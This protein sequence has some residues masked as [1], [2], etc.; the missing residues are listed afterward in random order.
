MSYSQSKYFIICSASRQIRRRVPYAGHLMTPRRLWLNKIPTLCDV[1]IEFP[2]KKTIFRPFEFIHV[3]STK[4]TRS[5]STI[6]P[7]FV[8]FFSFYPSKNEADAPDEAL[9][10]L[11]TRIRTQ[12]PIGLGLQA[13]VKAHESSKRTAFYISAPTNV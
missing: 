1:V 6:L 11:L 5:R 13:T 7:Q 3:I 10:W 12:P 9:R 8:H 2:G 4:N